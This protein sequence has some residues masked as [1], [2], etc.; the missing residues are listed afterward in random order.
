MLTSLLVLGEAHLWMLTN[1]LLSALNIYQVQNIYKTRSSLELDKYT[2]FHSHLMI[3]SP[4]ATLS[5]GFTTGL[6]LL[7]HYT[8]DH[9]T[10]LYTK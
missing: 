9:L 4:G 7:G 1:S 2:T 3:I 5:P 8:V 6:G 10:S